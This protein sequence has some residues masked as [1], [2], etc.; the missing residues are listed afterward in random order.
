MTTMYQV[1]CL[2]EDVS[3]AD[4]YG[5]EESPLFDTEHEAK[6]FMTKCVASWPEGFWVREGYQVNEVEA[7]IG[8]ENFGIAAN[9][10]IAN[11]TKGTR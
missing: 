9:N 7:F 5:Q 3:A 8:D 4:A 6:E 10:S 1:Q 2:D 11:P